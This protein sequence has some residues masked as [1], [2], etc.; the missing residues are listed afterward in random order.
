[1]PYQRK[2]VQS[3]LK[4]QSFTHCPSSSKSAVRYFSEAVAHSEEAYKLET[5]FDFVCDFN[6]NK[7]LKTQINE[8]PDDWGLFKAMLNGPGGI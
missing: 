4:Q 2:T 3:G 5:G 6:G 7:I 8:T 1:M